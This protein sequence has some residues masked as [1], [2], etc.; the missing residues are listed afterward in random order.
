MVKNQE[1]DTITLKQVGSPIRRNAMQVEH[2]KA[3]G[4]GK[5]HKQR[6]LND[7]PAIRG[8]LKKVSH[9]VCVVEK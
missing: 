4:L 3:L 9:M 8:L 1:P 7:T 6:T 5:M 2:L